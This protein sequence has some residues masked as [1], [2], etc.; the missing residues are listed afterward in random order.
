VQRIIVPEQLSAHHAD[1]MVSTGSALRDH[2]ASGGK[3]RPRGNF[4]AAKPQKAAQELLDTCTVDGHPPETLEDLDS[5]LTHLRA[6]SVVATLSERWAQVG[7][8]ISDGPLALRLASLAEAYARLKHVVVHPRAEIREAHAP[9]RDT[10]NMCWP[11]VNAV[12][13]D[14]ADSQPTT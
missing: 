13:N 9:D 12:L 7:V 5:V 14:L 2:L 4:R 8:P 3:L 6:H 10:L 1:A 11:V